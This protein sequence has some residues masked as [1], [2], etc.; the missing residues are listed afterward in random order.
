[1]ALVR[2]VKIAAGSRD[3]M[4]M[5]LY[6]FTHIF[7]STGFNI[8][9]GMVTGTNLPIILSAPVEIPVES[10]YVCLFGSPREKDMSFVHGVFSRFEDRFLT[11]NDSPP[12]PIEFDMP[13]LLASESVGHALRCAGCFEADPVK[14]KRAF[15]KAYSI[16]EGVLLS[17]CHS[18]LDTNIKT[19]RKGPTKVILFQPFATL[20]TD[21]SPDGRRLM[22]HCLAGMALCSL[23][24]EGH[25]VKYVSLVSMSVC[26]ASVRAVELA[27]VLRMVPYLMGCVTISVPV[28]SALDVDALMNFSAAH[29]GV[30][31]SVTENVLLTLLVSGGHDDLLAAEL[32]LIPDPVKRAR[33]ARF[34]QE[35]AQRIAIRL[36]S[37]AP[38][39]TVHTRVVDGR[40]LERNCAGCGVWDRTGKSYLRCSR[41]MG[42][43]YCCK[44][45]Q[46]GH[47]KEH[48]V[49]CAKK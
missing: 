2:E 26:M 48:K 7:R 21:F 39:T 17:V 1:M 18:A 36:S 12:S 15:D 3:S 49:G 29:F 44:E 32:Q 25:S 20:S 22:S 4:E 5:D 33:C 34:A 46:V 45:C 42:V 19:L 11:L 28:F 37:P 30:Q 16:Y 23:M 8:R 10:P 24:G 47:W 14:R 41:C 40:I 31:N 43:Y 27:C 9:F 38:F 13:Q 35:S 6:N